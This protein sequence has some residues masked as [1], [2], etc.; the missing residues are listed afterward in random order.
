MPENPFITQNPELSDFIKGTIQEKRA[1]YPSNRQGRRA[2]IRAI[3]RVFAERGITLDTDGSH[4]VEEA[5][6]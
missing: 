4:I 3:R 5:E 2:A 1:K 6:D